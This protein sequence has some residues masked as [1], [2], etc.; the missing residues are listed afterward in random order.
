MPSGAGHVRVIAGEYMGNRGPA[1]TFTP[2]DVWDLR[3]A[4][5]HATRFTLPEGRTL[6][7]V[8]LRGRVRVN[9]DQQV[10]VVA[11]RPA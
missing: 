3:L 5:G 7:L 10:D 6:A 4:G 1:H 2:M 9:G 11:G 8:A